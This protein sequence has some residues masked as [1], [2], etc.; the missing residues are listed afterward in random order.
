VGNADPPTVATIQDH[1]TTATV[2]VDDSCLWP[3]AFSFAV[4]LSGIAAASTPPLS[5]GGL[6]RGTPRVNNPNAIAIA[7]NTLVAGLNA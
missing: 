7:R 1:S 4:D 5:F 2:V 3:E 6:T